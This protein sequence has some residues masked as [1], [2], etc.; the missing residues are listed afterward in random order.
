MIKN[1]LLEFKRT[2][3]PRA[4]IPVRY[5]KKA[6]SEKIVFNVLGF[7]ILYM[8]VFII[9][10][11]VLGAMGIDFE[12][13]VG[14]SAS[15]LGNVGPAFG[16]LHPLANFNGLPDVGKWWCSFLMLL[17][18][19]ELFTVLILFMPIFWKRT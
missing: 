10:A 17:G 1:G 7:F 13:A 8:L 4:I 15:S 2:L 3:H 19:L 14:G 5:N 18:R 9:G 12:T 16:Q 6:V 11:V